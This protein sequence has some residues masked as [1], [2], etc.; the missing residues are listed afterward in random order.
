M[1]WKNTF[2]VLAIINGL[3]LFSI[4]LLV[5][6]NYLDIGF[7]GSDVSTQKVAANSI[8]L[9]PEMQIDTVPKKDS[10][11]IDSLSKYDIRL[12]SSK[13]IVLIDLPKKTEKKKQ[14]TVSKKQKSKQ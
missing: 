2:K 3:I 14:D 8:G 12:A 6:G 7:L 4:F 1:R 10:V 9:P 5:R 11:K 13:T